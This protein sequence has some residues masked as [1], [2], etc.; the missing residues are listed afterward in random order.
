[1]PRQ[2]VEQLLP[3]PFCGSVTAPKLM[4]SR[5]I[6]NT[7][8]GS[9]YAVCCRATSGGCGAVGGYRWTKQEALNRWQNRNIR[10]WVG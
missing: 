7:A 3:C 1:M 9:H 10:G 5:E 2:T 8:D 4:D 6:N